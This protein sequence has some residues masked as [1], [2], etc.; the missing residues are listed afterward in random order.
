LGG[1][2]F[3]LGQDFDF[4]CMFKTNFSG[5]KKILGTQKDWVALPPNAPLGNA[6]ACK[7]TFSHLDENIAALCLWLNSS[8]SDDLRTKV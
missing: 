3:L 4:Y 6:P 2:T 8:K 5:H 7:A 1:N